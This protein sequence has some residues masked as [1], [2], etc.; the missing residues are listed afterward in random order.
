MWSLAMPALVFINLRIYSQE[1]TMS[2]E[3]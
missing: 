2:L 1:S 3:Q